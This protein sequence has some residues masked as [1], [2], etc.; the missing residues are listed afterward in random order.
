VIRTSGPVCNHVGRRYESPG[1]C[2]WQSTSADR[3]RGRG[4]IAA[5]DGDERWGEVKASSI[6]EIV[7]SP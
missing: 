4:S 3:G 7:D 1:F 5:R 2:E 6:R